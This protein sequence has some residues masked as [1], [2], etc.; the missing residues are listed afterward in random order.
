MEAAPAKAGGSVEYSPTV[1]GRRLIREIERLRHDSGLSMEAAAQRLGWSASKMYRLENGRSRITT[2]DLEDMLDLYG[3]RSPQREAFIQLGRDARRRGWWTAYADIFT[4]SYISMEAE[5]AS[6]RVNAHVVP[7]IFQV[8]GYAREVI[9]RTRPA[10]SAE[11]AE[12]R[13]AARVARQ[14]AFFSRDDPPEVHVVLEEAV[15]YR[16]VGGLAVTR[17][18]LAA[19]AEAAAR[20]DVIIQVLPFAVGANAGMDGKFTLLAFPDPEDPPVAYVEGLMGDVYI[21][22]DEE[23]D[24]FSLAWTHLV[25]QALDPA[26][27]AIMIRALA[28]E[29]Q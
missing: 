8:P 28:K 27:S 24:R 17:G 11:D 19:L 23:V 15:L 12:R 26:E 14:E 25:T 21:E 7:G 29:Q 22:A 6:I 5:A 13:V 1:R 3:V 20:P 4:G 9:A 18:Q 10:I 16:Q 2:D